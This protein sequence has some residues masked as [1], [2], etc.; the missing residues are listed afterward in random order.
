MFAFVLL[1]MQWILIPVM[2][3]IACGL[4]CVMGCALCGIFK[5]L[6]N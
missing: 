6:K 3:F 5:G 1:I 4:G 2:V